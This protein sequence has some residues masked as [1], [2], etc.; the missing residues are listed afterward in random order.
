MLKADNLHLK[1][2]LS[3]LRSENSNLKVKVRKLQDDLTKR[4]RQIC[5]LVD[6]K[7]SSNFRKFISEHGA[8]MF[9]NMKEQKDELYKMLLEKEKHIKK[10]QNELQ[11][12]SLYAPIGERRKINFNFDV[13]PSTAFSKDESDRSSTYPKSSSLNELRNKIYNATIDNNPE[14]LR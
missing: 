6:P 5:N 11:I 1:R 14:L 2:Q 9:L 7:K 8:A 10:L 12:A 4:Q 3:I 13:R